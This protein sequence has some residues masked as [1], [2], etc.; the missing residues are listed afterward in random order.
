MEKIRDFEA[1]YEKELVPLLEES[2][3]IRRETRRKNFGITLK[4]L[5]FAVVVIVVAFLVNRAIYGSWNSSDSANVPLVAMIFVTCGL[6]SVIVPVLS[7]MAT[8]IL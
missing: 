2:D 6:P 8:C 3:Q 7:N 1:Y 5:F 4:Y